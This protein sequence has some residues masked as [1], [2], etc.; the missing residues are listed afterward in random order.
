MT[1]C[2]AHLSGL[3]RSREV[4]SIISRHGVLVLLSKIVAVYEVSRDGVLG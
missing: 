4:E 2:P 1:S 3:D